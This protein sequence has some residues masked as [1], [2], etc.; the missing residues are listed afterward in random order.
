MPSNRAPQAGALFLALVG[1]T[2]AHVR[3][4]SASVA[5]GPRSAAAPRARCAALAAWEE[6]DGCQVLRPSTA[7][8]RGIV[9]FLGGVFASPS[10]QVL[11]R[12]MLQRLASKGYVVIAN[13]YAVDFDYL[14]TAD[15]ILE[16]YEMVLPAV[17]RQYPRELPQFAVGHSLGA[18]MHTT[19]GSLFAESMPKYAGAVLVSHNNKQ[20]RDAIPGFDNVVAPSLAPYG[21]FARLPSYRGLLDSARALRKSTFDLARDVVQTS[22]S[23]AAYASILDDVAELSGLIDQVPSVLEGIADGVIEFTPT[24][25]ELR[26]AL[27]SS[28]ALP[29][30]LVVSFSQD[31]I[32]ESDLLESALVGKPGVERIRLIGTHTTPLAPDPTTIPVSLMRQFL[33]ASVQ[34]EELMSAVQ[35]STMRDL[36]LLV[37]RIDDWAQRVTREGEAAAAGPE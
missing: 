20:L 37:D 11:Y 35:Q 33:P 18:L 13:P 10:P 24:P 28:Y 1:V 30:S 21:E 27:R 9:H 4:R 19:I 2:H 36:D 34:L 22:P 3:A 5:V 15:A 31:S 32:D 29:R 16:R 6:I 17:Q 14:Q 12:H 7:E 26:R 25:D 23:T 8:P